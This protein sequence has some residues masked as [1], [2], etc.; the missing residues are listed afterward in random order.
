MSAELL[1]RAPAL[2]RH[3]GV[4]VHAQIERWLMEEITAGAISAG[5]RLP[6]ERELAAALRVSRMTLRQA[7][8]GLARRGVLV[9]TPGRSGGAFVAEPR[10]DCDLTG[11]AGFTEQMRRAHR[12]AGAQV[13]TARTVDADGQVSRALQLPPGAPVYELVRVRSA[14]GT[15][16]AL[17]RT[18]LPADR[19]PGLLGHPLTGSIYELLADEYGLAPHT[20][21]EYLEPVSADPATAAALGVVRGTPLMGVERTA[22]SVGGLAVEYARDLY[23][24]DKVRLMVRTEVRRDDGERNGAAGVSE[25]SPAS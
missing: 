3:R 2:K 6:G 18:W 11:V 25:P 14:D 15:A 23:R 16:L 13:L 12:R 10:I 24:A 4:P 8:D 19:L 5:D 21:V 20:A 9:R 7:L 22:H 17:E 1:E